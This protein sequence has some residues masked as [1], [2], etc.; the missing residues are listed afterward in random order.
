MVPLGSSE[1]ILGSSFVWVNLWY[2]DVKRNSLCD[3]LK[4]GEQRQPEGSHGLRIA[5]FLVPDIALC[6]A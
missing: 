6:S 1:L 5:Y 2:M 3:I 4:I